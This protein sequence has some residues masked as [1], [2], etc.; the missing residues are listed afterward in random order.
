[1]KKFSIITATYNRSALLKDAYTALAEQTLRD[2]EW[3]IIDDGSTDNTKEKVAQWVRENKIPIKY[4]WQENQGKHVAIN[5]A[6]KKAE[7][8][9]I[10][11]LDADDIPQRCALENF[12]NYL[13]E[14]VL[15]QKDCVGVLVLCADPAGEIIGT[16][17]PKDKTCGN[18]LDLY[19]RQNVKG[20]K[21]M[22]WR[23][24]ILENFPFPEIDGEK[25]MPEAIV[26]NRIG[27]KYK[28]FC[29]NDALLKVRYQADG[30]SASSKSLRVKNPKGTALYYKEFIN[31]P[32]SFY[33]KARNMVNYIRFSFH[34]GTGLAE[35]LKELKGGMLKFLWINTLPFGFLFYLKDGK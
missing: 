1:M 20:D 2:F 14:G 34:S 29:V 18:L 6:V 17:F 19:Y 35:Q 13:K 10:I 4:L 25:F 30:L 26:W 31:L 5:N 7:G 9:F 16:K 3:I 22:C 15:N 27:L 28:V 24:N 11:I 32:V 12:A 23:K 21:W 33:W 8:D